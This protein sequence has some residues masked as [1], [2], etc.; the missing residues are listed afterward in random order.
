M[1]DIDYSGNREMDE[2][3]ILLTTGKDQLEDHWNLSIA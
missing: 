2:P 1:T 3:V